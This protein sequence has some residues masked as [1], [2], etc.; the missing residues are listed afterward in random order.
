MFFGHVVNLMEIQDLSNG[1]TRQGAKELI[2]ELWR[3]DGIEMMFDKHSRRCCKPEAISG[4]Y[5]KRQQRLL[6]QFDVDDLII[7]SSLLRL[8]K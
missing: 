4:S 5:R 8:S 3:L 1:R 7:V 6:S 2:K